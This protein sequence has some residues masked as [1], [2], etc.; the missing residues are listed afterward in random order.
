MMKLLKGLRAALLAVPLLFG[1]IPA[2]AATTA[3][4]GG[5]FNFAWSFDTG[6]G[7]TITGTGTLST[8]LGAGNDLFVTVTLNNTTA[9]PAGTNMALM[10][11]GFGIDPNAAAVSISGG[12]EMLDASLDSIP[13]LAVIEVCAWA[14]NNCNGGPVG[15][16]IA[17]GGSDTFTLRLD[18]AAANDLWGSTVTIEPIGFKFQG[19]VGSFSSLRR[20]RPRPR[21]LLRGRLRLHRERCPSR[22]RAPW[23]CWVSV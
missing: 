13:S 10:S 19:T 17:A 12:T 18:A 11:F 3:T 20:P 9:L 6:A 22:A 1:A 16:G 15:D 8:A 14:G 2:Q 7:V 21:R 23:H 4:D 5:G